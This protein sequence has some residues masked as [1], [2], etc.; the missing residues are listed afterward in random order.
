MS[1][2]TQN[3]IAIHWSTPFNCKVATNRSTIDRL[4]D[5]R[6]S[7]VIGFLWPFILRALRHFDSFE[8]SFHCCLFSSRLTYFSGFND[9]TTSEK[10]TYCSTHLNSISRNQQVDSWASSRCLDIYFSS[11]TEWLVPSQHFF[12]SYLLAASDYFFDMDKQQEEN[13]EQ[14]SI[15]SCGK[16]YFSF[17]NNCQFSH[18]ILYSCNLR[19]W[20]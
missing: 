19:V 13:L 15:L 11:T 18:I 7:L 5:G 8:L 2:H 20:K 6:Q 12:L 10:A 9:A 14:L 1:G 4:G 3:T 17:N 16:Q